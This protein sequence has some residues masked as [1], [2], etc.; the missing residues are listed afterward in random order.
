MRAGALGISPGVVPALL[1]AR[2]TTR[3]LISRDCGQGPWGLVVGKHCAIETRNSVPD[4]A[5]SQAKKMSKKR[6]LFLIVPTEN[7]ILLKNH[8]R[9]ARENE[10]CR[11]LRLL[12]SH[13]WIH[14]LS[15]T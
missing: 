6:P 4:L 8:K 13:G 15:A 14:E 3:V 7:S 5:P 1:E 12:C 2:V 10:V 11:A 9:Q